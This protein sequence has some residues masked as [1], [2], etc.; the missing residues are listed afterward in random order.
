LRY[1][2]ISDGRLYLC[3]NDSSIKEIESKFANEKAEIADRTKSRQGWKVKGEAFGGPFSSSMIWGNQSSITPYVKFRF[4]NIGFE[5]Q[6]T[7]Y[8]LL[9]NNFVT[10]LFKYT[11][12][13]NYEQ[14]LFHKQEMFVLGIDYS[15]VLKQFVISTV[16][17]DRSAGLELLDEQG[18]YVQGLTGGDSKDSNPYFSR[19][20]PDRV[21]YQ[22]AGIVRDENGFMLMYGPEAIS[23]VDMKTGEVSVCLSDDKYDYLL[24]KDDS[25]GNLYCIR[26]PH[27]GPRYRSIWKTLWN[28]VSFPVRFIIAVVNFLE[29]FTKLFNQKPFQHAGPDFGQPIQNKYLNV[30]GQ[31]IDLARIKRSLRNPDN[32]SL[33]PRTW[34]LI[35]ISKDERMEIIAQKVSY[36]DIDADNKIHI[37]NGFRV[38]EFAGDK[39]QQAFKYNLIEDFKAVK[40]AM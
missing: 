20:N 10:G 37:T 22:S 30:L 34:E 28:I 29:A 16:A 12:D 3:D 32:V 6:N 35:R 7:L 11:I 14:R 15:P 25:E 31:T 21:F 9:S 8:Y 33:V 5:D 4:R 13:E 18:S 2:F 39:S 26:R 23:S 24:P 38:S 36:Y 1:A 40:S 17:E 19:Q 27:Q